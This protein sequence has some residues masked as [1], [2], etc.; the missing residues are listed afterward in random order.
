MSTF[1]SYKAV[2]QQRQRCCYSNTI[3]LKQYPIGQH[4][5]SSSATFGAVALWRGGVESGVFAG[6]ELA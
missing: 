4:Y 5:S 6:E 1:G 2:P 3:L